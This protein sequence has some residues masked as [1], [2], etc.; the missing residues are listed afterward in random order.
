MTGSEALHYFRSDISSDIIPIEF[1]PLKMPVLCEEVF[2]CFSAL[3]CHLGFSDGIAGKIEF[4]ED[5]MLLQPL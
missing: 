1:Q 3:W 5:L 4:F 2:E